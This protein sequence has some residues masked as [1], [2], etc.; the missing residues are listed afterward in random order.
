[1]ASAA[2]QGSDFP[3]LDE[4]FPDEECLARE[5]VCSWVTKEFLPVIQEH[6]RQDGSFPVELVPNIAELGVLGG[7]GIVDD[8]QAMRRMSNLGTVH[9]Y[10]GT[11][12]IHTLILVWNNHALL[13][14]QKRTATSR[15][16]SL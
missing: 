1:M 16:Q 10:E 5:T 14:L 3:L 7:N 15:R 12:D 13:P 2:F 8:Y 11:H 9:T 6:A 4:E